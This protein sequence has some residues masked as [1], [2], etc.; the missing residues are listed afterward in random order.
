MHPSPPEQLRPSSTAS[1]AGP[2]PSAP[3]VI[4]LERKVRRVQPRPILGRLLCLC[5]TSTLAVGMNLPAQLVVVK[6]TSAYHGT[7]LGHQEIDTGALLPMMGRAGR[8]GFDESATAVI[9]TDLHSRTKY[10]NV[11]QGL[12]VFE[13]HLMEDHKLT[14]VFNVE[15]ISQGVIAS[16]DEAVDWLKESFLF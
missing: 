11:S 8:P 13:S 16:V 9:M 10:E 6:G 14:E 4:L 12:K 7:E 5:T 3:I 1:T 2:D 15:E